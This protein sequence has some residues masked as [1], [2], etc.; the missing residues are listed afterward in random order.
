MVDGKEVRS[1][2]KTA[3]QQEP[4]KSEEVTGWHLESATPS[5]REGTE[6]KKNCYNST[7]SNGDCA[8]G[9]VHLFDQGLQGLKHLFENH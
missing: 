1:R 9:Y 3:K 4:Q 2:A 6:W 8:S 7:G 5:T